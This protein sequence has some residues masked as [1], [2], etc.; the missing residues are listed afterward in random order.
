MSKKK[1]N[2]ILWLATAGGRGHL[3]RACIMRRLLAQSDIEVQIMTTSDEG[4]SFLRSHGCPSTLLSKHYKGTVFDDSQNMSRSRTAAGVLTYLFLPTRCYAD[5]RKIKKT[6]KNFDLVIND[7]F[8]P[9]LMLASIFHQS[10]MKVVQVYG[11]NQRR[12][13]LENL[14]RKKGRLSFGLFH[15]LS[16]KAFAEAYGRVIHSHAPEEC[17]KKYKDAPQEPRTYILPPMVDSMFKSKEQVR[18][19]FAVAP[20][21]KLAV[22]YL[23]P[24]FK[25]PKLAAGLEE[26][27][28]ECGFRIHAV[29]EGFRD[30]EKWIPHDPALIN[31]IAA[32]DLFISAPGV[33]A[34]AQ[35]KL[36]GIPFLAVTSRQP[37]QEYNRDHL[38]ALS[39]P[40]EQIDSEDITAE[41][42][43]SVKDK[44]C[45]LLRRS[46]LVREQ[47]PSSEAAILR[48][49][50]LWSEAIRD[51]LS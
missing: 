33:A 17:R 44:I 25:N 6:A 15:R 13:L 12:A 42:K 30:R 1:R 37:E 27:L 20:G 35:V 5:L 28:G 8:H 11:E 43:E 18:S 46:D 23:N 22:V 4:V 47:G 9:A 51:L 14:E 7:A 32:S 31:A 19:E 39:A 38:K 16:N 41:F 34:L 49:H 3:M 36:F 2:R 10:S 40:W 21:K 26:A 24:H 50:S 29:G 48:V 45:E